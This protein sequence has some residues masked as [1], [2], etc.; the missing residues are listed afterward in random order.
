MSQKLT[1]EAEAEAAE[2]VVSMNSGLLGNKEF[3]KRRS[4]IAN[5]IEASKEIQIKQYD[6]T[7]LG[8]NSSG[9]KKSSLLATQYSTPSTG[10]RDNVSA[11]ASQQSDI[12]KT[13]YGAAGGDANSTQQNNRPYYAPFGTNNNNTSS[14]TSAGISFSSS[15]GAN[16]TN[17]SNYSNYYMQN[18]GTQVSS[19]HQYQQQ[20]QNQLQKE[21]SKQQ[22]QQSSNYYANLNNYQVGGQLNKVQYKFSAYT[23]KLKPAPAAKTEAER[24]TAA[25]S[26]T[27]GDKSTE[28]SNEMVDS[29]EKEALT[30][31]DIDPSKFTSVKGVRLSFGAKRASDSTPR[32]FSCSYDGCPWS[33]ARQSDQRRHIRSHEKPIFHC[34]YWKSDPTCHR[35]G[36]AFNRLDVLKR[37]LRLVHFVQFKQSDSGWCRICQKMFPNP[38]YFVSHCEKCAE[39]ARPAQWRINDEVCGTITTSTNYDQGSENALVPSGSV[40]VVSSSSFINYKKK[41]D[42]G[43]TVAGSDKRL[44]FSKDMVVHQSAPMSTKPKITRTRVRKQHDALA[45]AKEAEAAAAAIASAGVKGATSTLSAYTMKETMRSAAYRQLPATVLDSIKKDSYS[46][47]GDTTNMPLDFSRSDSGISVAGGKSERIATDSGPH[48]DKSDLMGASTEQELLLAHMRDEQEMDDVSVV[49]STLVVNSGPG[50]MTQPLYK[51]IKRIHHNQDEDLV[52]KRQKNNNNN[53]SKGTFQ[54]AAENDKVAAESDSSDATKES[55]K[56]K[57]KGVTDDPTQKRAP[58]F[59]ASNATAASAAMAGASGVPGKRRTKRGRPS[60]A[61]LIMRMYNS[62]QAAEGEAGGSS[63][64]AGSSAMNLS[65]SGIFP[66]SAHGTRTRGRG[67]GSNR[68]TLSSTIQAGHH[69]SK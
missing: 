45:A 22:S 66:L 23:D 21:P 59:T 12:Y 55:T 2:A 5:L 50:P 10:N 15:V 19:Y 57:P 68:Q 64:S 24:D 46:E 42:S 13:T 67:A 43:Q 26:T 49:T 36:G 61:E 39:E 20:Q 53:G 41:D 54:A 11:N 32:P 35:N 16:T 48:M 63:D 9:P 1:T 60:N 7:R 28:T 38:K 8:N 6:P 47:N 40:P 29:T 51:G 34:P 58:T 3:F 56:T 31:E 18:Y 62:K 30:E 17:G 14:T 52:S 69:V 65:G 44:S 4:S 33:F 37:H 27:V 25:E